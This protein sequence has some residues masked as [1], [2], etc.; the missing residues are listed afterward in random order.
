MAID[1]HS[2]SFTFSTALLALS[3]ELATWKHWRFNLYH[4]VRNNTSLALF[5][6]YHLV[7]IAKALRLLVRVGNPVAF[8]CPDLGFL[9]ADHML[10]PHVLCVLS[11]EFSYK[12][13]IPEFT[14]HA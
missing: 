13:R 12:S 3:V 2:G 9:L 10:C 1:L 5:Y 4:L 7:S 8:A 6:G 14:S 11:F